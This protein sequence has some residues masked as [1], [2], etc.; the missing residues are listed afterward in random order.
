[1]SAVAAAAA[2]LALA[3]CATMNVSSY[4]DRRVDFTQFK[5]YAW[6]PR[7]DLATGD[8]RLDN[9]PFFHDRV[10]ADVE[11]Q[12]AG[13]GFE[14]ASSGAPDLVLHY[15]ASVRQRLDLSGVDQRYGTCDDCWAVV[16]DAGTLTLDMVDA[17]S[18]RL[19]WRGWAERSIDGPVD[20]QEL[21][22]QRI[23]RAV[24]RIIERL[25]P[26]L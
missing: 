5:T 18:N 8:P 15:H 1:M 10:R 22:E 17:R 21:F 7:V 2:A 14:K 6:E 4:V 9:N 23:D 3:G 11:R 26:T 19:I 13:R 12:L 24:Q 16:F 25:P 20:D